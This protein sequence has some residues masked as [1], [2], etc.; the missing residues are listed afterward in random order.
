MRLIQSIDQST[1]LCLSTGRGNRYSAKSIPSYFHSMGP[2]FVQ[3][4]E[5]RVRKGVWYD[6][7]PRSKASV[8]AFKQTWRYFEYCHD[9]VYL[10]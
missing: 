4:N 10:L 7:P 3:R 9:H 6:V 8:G 1:R 2:A 5:D